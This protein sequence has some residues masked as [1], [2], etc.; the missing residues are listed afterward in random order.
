MHEAR[1]RWRYRPPD[2]A[3][4]HGHPAEIAMVERLIAR[5]H[6]YVAANGDVYYDSGLV[7]YGRLS[8]KSIGPA[9]RRACRAWRSEA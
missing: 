4:G 3:Q 1:Q 7:D 5:G 8:G 2:Q 9:V 6:A